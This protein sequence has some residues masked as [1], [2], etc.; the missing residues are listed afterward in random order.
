MKHISVKR[1]Q[2]FHYYRNT[3]H[4]HTEFEDRSV[5][6]RTQF[7]SKGFMAQAVRTWAI[8]PDGRNE[9]P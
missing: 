8:N 7:F 2:I 5:R 3:C 6:L 9:A 4:L 1:M